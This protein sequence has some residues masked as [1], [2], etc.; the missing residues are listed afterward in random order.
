MVWCARSGA[1]ARDDLFSHTNESG[2]ITVGIRS[3]RLLAIGA[4]LA[5][6]TAPTLARQ[7]PTG[8]DDPSVYKLELKSAPEVKHGKVAV[9][10]GVAWPSGQKMALSDLSVLQPVEVTLFVPNVEDD[11]R[12]ELSKFI[13][14]EPARTGSTKGKASVNFKFRTQGDLQIRVVSPDGPNGYRLLVWV[15]DEVTPEMPAPFISMD[16]YQKRVAAG[17]AGGGAPGAAGA[18]SAGGSGGAPVVL[19]VIAG[20]LLVIVALLSIIVLRRKRA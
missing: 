14:D 13:L 19:W 8:A 9:V 12:L 17:T 20:A 4:L 2:V 15:G 6:T 3:S 1:R 11:V 7:N 10:E 16:T 18:T 5:V